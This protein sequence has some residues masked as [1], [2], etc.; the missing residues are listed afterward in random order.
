MAA[1]A[2]FDTNGMSPNTRVA[3]NHTFAYLSS[4]YKV[5]HFRIRDTQFYVSKY[6]RG[7]QSLFYS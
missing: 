6:F 2:S 5:E 4:V 7:K 3:P 1:G